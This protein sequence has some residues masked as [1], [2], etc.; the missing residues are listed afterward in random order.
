MEFEEE[1]IKV[2]IDTSLCS[3]CTSKACVAACKV[4]SRGILQLA[5]GKPSV[6]HLRSQEARKRGTECLGCE[7]ECRFRGRS[8]IRIEI[9]I[10]GLADYRAKRGIG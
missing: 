5:D 9:P 6:S 1:T 3:E 10:K 8:A 4:Y 7:Y 2:N